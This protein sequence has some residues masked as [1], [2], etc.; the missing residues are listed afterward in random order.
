MGVITSSGGRGRGV[1]DVPQVVLASSASSSSDGTGGGCIRTES[2]SQ[3]GRQAPSAHIRTGAPN[4]QD[5]L[6][7]RLPN[8]T[9]AIRKGITPAKKPAQISQPTSTGPGV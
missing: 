3:G 7:M 6:T 1:A 5:A 4:C 8:S 2:G 9:E